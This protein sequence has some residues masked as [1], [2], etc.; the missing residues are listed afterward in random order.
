MRIKVERQEGRIWRSVLVDMATSRNGNF[1]FKHD[2]KIYVFKEK[3]KGEQVLVLNG[4]E[5][6][7]AGRVTRSGIFLGEGT[8]SDEQTPEGLRS[9]RLALQSFLSK[10]EP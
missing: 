1:T 7:Q 9:A 3:R 5:W 8:S 6:V 10:K 2:G 4:E